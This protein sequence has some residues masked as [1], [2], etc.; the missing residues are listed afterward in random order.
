MDRYLNGRFLGAQ[1]NT[2]GAA[3]GS[4]RVVMQ[5]GQALTVGL[6]DTAGAERFE[7]LSKVYYH[8]AGAA[9]VCY[10]P[11]DRGSLE[12]AKFW[13]QELR[14]T[15]PQCS[16]YV[17][18]CKL[19]LLREE[20]ELFVLEL[21]SFQL[22]TTYSLNAQVASILNLSQDHL[23]RYGKF[24]DYLAA[25]QRIYDGCQVAVWNRDDL[26]TRPQTQVPREIT[27]GSHPEAGVIHLQVSRHDHAG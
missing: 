7:S 25:K 22:E 10:D 5:D 19:D 13:V 17:A 4:K 12:K 26:A 14:E 24:S 16:I 6:W 23:D 11:A 2:I 27:F 1:K 15:E 21:S 3:F 8:G 20:A 18:A 9:V